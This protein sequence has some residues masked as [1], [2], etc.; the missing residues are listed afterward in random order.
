MELAISI[1]AIIISVL[2]IIV[3]MMQNRSAGL[4]QTF[5]GDGGV[6]FEKRGAE[7]WMYYATIILSILFLGTSLALLL[8]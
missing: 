2:L 4:S 7:K 3:I 1:I 5:G 6:Q 8:I